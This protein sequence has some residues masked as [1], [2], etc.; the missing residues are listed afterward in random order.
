MNWKNRLTS[1]S[2]MHRGGANLIMFPWV[3]LASKPS[4][5]KTK[6]MWRSVVDEFLMFLFVKG[7]LSD[8]AGVS[9]LSMRHTHTERECCMLHMITFSHSPNSAMLTQMSHASPS[10]LAF[11]SK[12]SS[13]TIAFNSPLPRISM[14]N[15]ELKLAMPSLKRFPILSALPARSSSTST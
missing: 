13:M 3:G 5:I 9:G 2:V 12:D 1:A 4:I 10:E 8:I 14:T 7:S 6:E 11:F 15:G